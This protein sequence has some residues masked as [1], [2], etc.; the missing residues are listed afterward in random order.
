MARQARH[1]RMQRKE[2]PLC[3]R[4]IMR[5]GLAPTASPYIAL[6]PDG[7][8]TSLSAGM[9]AQMKT[10]MDEGYWL[11]DEGVATKPPTHD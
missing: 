9:R 2:R 3:R 6:K 1:G 11:R 7:T 4:A 8:R 5:F 10:M